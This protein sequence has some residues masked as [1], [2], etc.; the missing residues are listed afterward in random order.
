MSGTGKTITWDAG[1]EF[2][3][4]FGENVAV[5][6]KATGHAVLS[7]LPFEMVTVPAGEYTYGS[8]DE[9]LTIDY[10]YEI[11]KYPVTNTDFVLYLL[12]AFPEGNGPTPGSISWNGSPL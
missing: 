9:I 4:T 8:G 2:D 7:G 1:S 12:D 10:D 11:M 6:I 5:V 3:G